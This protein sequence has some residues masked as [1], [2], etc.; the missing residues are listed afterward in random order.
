M[1]N[2]WLNFSLPVAALVSAVFLNT[3]T[4]A[5]PSHTDTLSPETAMTLMQNEAAIQLQTFVGNTEITAFSSNINGNLLEGYT[6]TISRKDAASSINCAIDLNETVQCAATTPPPVSTSPESMDD[7]CGP[8]R[9]QEILLNSPFAQNL[10]DPLNDYS[11]RVYYNLDTTG[12]TWHLCM[13]IYDVRNQN[14]IGALPARATSS[15]G[16][17]AYYSEQPLNGIDY[18]VILTQGNR[19]LF[20]R[21]QGANLL[22]E[23]FS[24]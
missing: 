7:R 15:T 13:N 9:P 11:V 20:R 19:Y 22:Y 17:T 23:G 5:Q 24:R 14:F 6:A 3:P 1:R 21:S 18:Q 10:S 2:S 8:E 16:I 4:M 12:T